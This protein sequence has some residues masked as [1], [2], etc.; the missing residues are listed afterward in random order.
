MAS[1]MAK[2]RNTIN[3]HYILYEEEMDNE[4]PRNAFKELRCVMEAMLKLYSLTTGVEKEVLC[5][6]L[7]DRMEKWKSLSIHLKATG[8]DKKKLCFDD[9]IGHD[10]AKQ[11]LKSELESFRGAKLLGLQVECSPILLY[12]PAG[13]GK[14]YLAEAM[15]NECSSTYQRVC[16]SDL[17]HKYFGESEKAMKEIFDKARKTPKS[18]VFFDEIHL[19]FGSEEISRGLKSVFLTQMSSHENSDIVI[20][21]AT[22]MPWILETAILRRFEIKIGLTLP[23][24]KARSKILQKK[25][26]SSG[27]IF[28]VMAK[29]MEAI[30]K[31]LE[32]Y[33]PSDLA[34]VAKSAQKVAIQGVLKAKF[35]TS[36]MYNGQEIHVCCSEGDKGAKKI[37]MSKECQQ[38]NVKTVL[39]KPHLDYAIKK[40]GKSPTSFEDAEKLKKFER[41]Q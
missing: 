38:M 3:H 6:E 33:T 28:R 7:T 26:E 27:I 13:S 12:G 29:E 2:L 30:G 8:L 31:K 17:N 35:V 39:V 10:K 34:A 14:S 36:C 5:V 15:A 40:T 18:V 19:L 32:G 23:D 16:P 25:I 21:G 37:N 22:N 20:I 41:N 9:I 24:A 1:D 11:Y 4:K